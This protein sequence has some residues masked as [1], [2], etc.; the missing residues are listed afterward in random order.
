MRTLEEYLTF[1]RMKREMYV[2]STKFFTKRLTK[3]M[4]NSLIGKKTEQ[5]IKK[6]V[7]ST[8]E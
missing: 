3:L 5:L 1:F 2:R 6:N 4:C 7:K 8:N